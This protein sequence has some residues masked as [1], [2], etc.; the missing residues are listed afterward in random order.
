[1][2]AA[3][4]L[5]IVMLAVAGSAAYVAFRPAA[6]KPEPQPVAR[7]EQVIVPASVAAPAVAPVPAAVADEEQ[8]VQ[9][10]QPVEERNDAMLFEIDA[11]GNM[12]F[13]EAITRPFD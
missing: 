9:P 4:T 2:K 13:D 1:M 11:L 10:V 3:H 7:F 8:P 12:P 6:P 5:L